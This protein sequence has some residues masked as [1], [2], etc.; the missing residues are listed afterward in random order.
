MHHQLALV[1]NHFFFFKSVTSDWS[2][3]N[4]CCQC[5][6]RE[7]HTAPPPALASAAAQC[8]ACCIH[9]THGPPPFLSVDLRLGEG[10]EIR[11]QMEQKSESHEDRSSSPKK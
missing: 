10:R 6:L 4:R 5:L 1:K 7:G 2:E 8:Q 11:R 9:T 3:G